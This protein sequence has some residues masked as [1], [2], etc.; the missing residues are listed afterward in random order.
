MTI[1]LG[2]TYKDGLGRDVRIIATDAKRPFTPLVGLVSNGEGAEFIEAYREDGCVYPM[3]HSAWNLIIPK[4]YVELDEV[5]RIIN[6][7]S[8]FKDVMIERIEKLPVQEIAA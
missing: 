1:E 3:N 8:A 4:R 7:T 6:G 2:R 5:V